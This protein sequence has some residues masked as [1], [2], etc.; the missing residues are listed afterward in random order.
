[1]HYPVPV[2]FGIDSSS[3][4]A[5]DVYSLRTTYSTPALSP[6]KGTRNPA[7][8]GPNDG[9]K[10]L[11]PPEHS[12]TYVATNKELSIVD[13]SSFN[14]SAYRHKLVE[15]ALRK[16]YGNNYPPGDVVLNSIELNAIDSSSVETDLEVKYNGSFFDFLQ[17]WERA[18]PKSKPEMEYLHPL[19]LFVP[20]TSEKPITS[21][22]HTETLLST[23]DDEFS[24]RSTLPASRPVTRRRPN[25]RSLSNASSR[26]PLSRVSSKTPSVR[27]VYCGASSRSLS[28]ES[29]KRISSGALQRSDD[30]NFR[31][32]VKGKAN[33]PKIGHP[34]RP[35]TPDS[36]MEPIPKKFKVSKR[37][38]T[39]PNNRQPRTVVEHKDESEEEKAGV[40]EIP[41]PRTIDRVLVEENPISAKPTQVSMIP[42]PRTSNKSRQ[43]EIEERT[44][45]DGRADGPKRS[46]TG[47]VKNLESRNC[48]GSRRCGSTPPSRTVSR[49][50]SPIGR[51][52][53]AN[54]APRVSRSK[55]PT[56]AATP[57]RYKKSQVTESP[58]K[59]T[60]AN[61]ETPTVENTTKEESSLTI[62]ITSHGGSSH[63]R[64]VMSETSSGLN[65]SL[66]SSNSAKCI[67]QLPVL[68][69]SL[70]S[71]SLIGTGPRESPV[72]ETRDKSEYENVTA[73]K[74][75]V[76][77]RGGNM[78]SRG[79]SDS[80]K[81]SGNKPAIQKP[82]RSLSFSTARQRSCG[83][84]IAEGFNGVQEVDSRVNF[85]SENPL[86]R[87]DRESS[88]EGSAN[89]GEKLSIQRTRI[90]SPIPP[91][92]KVGTSHT[93]SESRTS[94]QS[95]NSKIAGSPERL[96]NQD[97]KIPEASGTQKDLSE[98][99]KNAELD[100]I[101]RMLKNK[102]RQRRASLSDAEYEKPKMQEDPGDRVAQPET[103][104][105]GTTRAESTIQRS[106]RNY[107]KKLKI[108]LS[109][110]NSNLAAEEM[111]SINLTDAIL[112]DMRSVLCYSELNK[113]EGLLKLAERSTVAERNLRERKKIK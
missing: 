107:I 102:T 34:D 3:G 76:P 7:A 64:N 29:A 66:D 84:K 86:R 52:K 101:S 70:S 110:E 51:P 73:E 2:R 47:K 31:V 89:V 32:E 78:M 61:R 83:K 23:D 85:A 98:S 43:P 77:R 49:N 28:S 25:S 13:I 18:H 95:A 50:P 80:K 90:P 38:H 44:I 96:K 4:S 108:V 45:V 79:E 99:A 94:K 93:S 104:E 6:R 69:S 55:L 16:I 105:S 92:Y 46:V 112:S 24:D 57:R 12:S 71:C 106:L 63:S 74:I 97:S 17:D 72:K 103:K 35:G 14:Y 75:A 48:V 87:K 22:K 36:C 33:P 40:P 30:A 15:S 10:Q 54:A 26:S 1:M 5:I 19:D 37:P 39:A 81:I 113:L 68:P 100:K 8:P 11:K 67:L 62:T 88:L 42:R 109:D 91:G 27:P 21:D 9:R 56:A 41:P 82:T 53:T 20:K 65:Q 111:A 59:S 60:A 58:P